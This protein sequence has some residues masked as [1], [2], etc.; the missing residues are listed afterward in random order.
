MLL[1]LTL[2]CDV[3]QLFGLTTDDSKTYVWS[4]GYDVACQETLS[5]LGF[6]CL[7]DAS[8]LGGAMTFG[9]AVRDRVLRYRGQSL[10]EKWMRLRRSLA[11]QLQKLAIL[12]KVFWPMALRDCIIS[13]S[14]VRDPRKQP[15][16]AIRLNGAGAN[17][18][19]RLTLSDDMNNDPGYFQLVTCLR[20]FKR[21]LTTSPDLLPFWKLR[22]NG[23]DG[24][25]FSGPLSKM[26]Q[27][28][29]AIIYYL[30]T[31]AGA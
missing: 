30:G 8:E 22:M 23:Y 9:Y 4:L 31:A 3:C 2:C 27:C 12:P 20:T 1:E 24:R 17:P 6:A 13:D 5:Q 26:L 19:L 11:P 25:L 15:V 14:Y 28:L 18:T 10:G 29:T 7:Q 16:K 21:I